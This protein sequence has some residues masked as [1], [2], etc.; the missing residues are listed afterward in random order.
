MADKKRYGPRSD[1]HGGVD[2]EPSSPVFT[3]LGSAFGMAIGELAL[4]LGSDGD[5]ELA[6]RHA[7]IAA[8][9][10]LLAGAGRSRGVC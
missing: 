1:P 6:L 2:R 10:A 5:V 9:A 8:K 7:E 4:A 3:S